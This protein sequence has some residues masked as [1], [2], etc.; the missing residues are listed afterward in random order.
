MLS[1]YKMLQKLHICLINMT[2]WKI[3]CWS[4]QR[5]FLYQSS[6]SN[7]YL[8][9]HNNVHLWCLK[10]NFI[11]LWSKEKTFTYS[12]RFCLPEFTLQ[13][14]WFLAQKCIFRTEGYT[15]YKIFNIYTIIT[16]LIIFK[17]SKR[18][19]DI[20]LKFPIGIHS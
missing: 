12:C 3:Y 6:A 13:H 15:W 9:C 7:L 8:N 18:H 4:L 2:C 17:K 16:R 20:C 14:W 10:T 19:Y 1:N 5:F 11:M